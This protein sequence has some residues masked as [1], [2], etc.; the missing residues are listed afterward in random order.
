MDLKNLQILLK[1]TKIIEI[2]LRKMIIY[3]IKVNKR[4]LKFYS[5]EQI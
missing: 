5:Y 2:V 1:P 3:L 4:K